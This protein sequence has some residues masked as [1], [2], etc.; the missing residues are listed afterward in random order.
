MEPLAALVADR[1]SAE[2]EAFHGLVA[3]LLEVASSAYS[4]RSDDET[5]VQCLQLLV[6]LCESSAPLLGK[7]LPAVVGLAMTVGTDNRA[8][9]PTREAALE[10]C[11]CVCVFGVMRRKGK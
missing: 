6:E 1:G 7:H 4:S 5:L 10:V 2:V 9:L 8:E 11:V 3:A